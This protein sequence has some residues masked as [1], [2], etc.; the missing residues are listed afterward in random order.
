MI[1]VVSPNNNR[2][3]LGTALS[4]MRNQKA[5][6]LQMNSQD[7]KPA[8]VNLTINMITTLWKGQHDRCGGQI[9]SSGI[10]PLGNAIV[11][12]SLSTT[13]VNLYSSNLVN[14]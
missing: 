7:F 3:T 8:S 6:H 12:V 10:V 14:S 4:D 9:Q 1:P 2:V 5:W 13:L 11:A